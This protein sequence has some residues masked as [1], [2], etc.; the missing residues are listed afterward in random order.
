VTA[1]AQE[2]CIEELKISIGFDHIPTNTYHADP[3]HMQMRQMAYNLSISMGH[4]MGLVKE[5]PSNP[6]STG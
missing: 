3:T 1:E 2:N 6:K 4:S 5:N